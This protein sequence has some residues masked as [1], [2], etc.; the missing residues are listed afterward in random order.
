MRLFIFILLFYCTFYPQVYGQPDKINIPGGALEVIPVNHGSFVLQWQNKIIY[1]DPYGGASLYKDIAP[2]D[3]I[4]VTDIHGDH[5][6]PETLLNLSLEKATILV[7]NAVAELLKKENIQ[8][9]KYL[10][11]NNGEQKEFENLRI[12]AVPMYNLPNSPEAR[13]PKGRG[14]GYIISSGSTKIYISGDTEDIPEMRNLKDIN[15]AFICMN[16]PYTMSINQAADAVLDFKPDIVY[17]YHYRGEGGKLSNIE[18]FKTMVNNKNKDIEVRL[19][20]WYS[21]K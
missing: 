17:P 10:T 9:A 1:I 16:L 12:E 21:K 11:I 2:P 5:Y 4:L 14:N 13:H 19:R 15:V 18:E 20:D 7:P 3:L 6:N 8:K